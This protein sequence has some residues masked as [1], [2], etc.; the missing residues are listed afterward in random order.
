MANGSVGYGAD[1]QRCGQCH[2]DRHNH[3]STARDWYRASRQFSFTGVNA[4]GTVTSAVDN[5]GPFSLN[6]ANAYYNA[7]R[8]ALERLRRVTIH[9]RD[10]R[11]HSPWTTSQW[12]GAA[13]SVTARPI[14]CRRTG[15]GGLAGAYRY[16]FFVFRTA[17]DPGGNN[18]NPA[19]YDSRSVTRQRWH[20]TTGFQFLN[21]TVLSAAADLRRAWNPPAP[22]SGARPMDR[23]KYIFRVSTGPPV[24]RPEIPG[25]RQIGGGGE[26]VKFSKLELSCQVPTLPASLIEKIVH[27]GFAFSRV[28][29][30]RK[31]KEAITG[32]PMP[33]PPRPVRLPTDSRAVSSETAPGPLARSP[34]GVT[35]V[36]AIVNWYSA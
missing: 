30:V 20:W 18:A 21:F 14:G 17:S 22:K 6:G 2:K 24:S 34:G 19:M 35:P 8:V 7:G 3:S 1:R 4:N 33:K 26:D 9:N 16:G 27:C 23:R 12:A 32:C 15:R 10:H 13:R 29:G 31:T 36:V 5:T 28:A 25:G 11:R